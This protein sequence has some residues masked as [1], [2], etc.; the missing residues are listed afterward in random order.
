VFF[1]ILPT[2]QTV[3]PIFSFM[4]QTTCIQARMA[5][6]GVR[7]IDDVIW[8][9]MIPNPQ[10]GGVNMQFPA[11]LQKILN[12]DVMKTIL[13]RFKPNFAQ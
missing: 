11:K 3:G 5:L 9:N 7:T 10:K 6:L 13:N 2:G 12:F 1:S 4:A 8:G